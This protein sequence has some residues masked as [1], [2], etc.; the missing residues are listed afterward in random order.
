MVGFLVGWLD[1]AFRVGLF[2]LTAGLLTSL[3]AMGLRWRTPRLDVRLSGDALVVDDKASANVAASSTRSLRIRATNTGR[4]PLNVLR[5]GLT[6]RGAP[7]PDFR[8]EGNESNVQV[9]SYKQTDAYSY[10]T[11]YIHRLRPG[12]FVELVADMPSPVTDVVADLDYKGRERPL[13]IGPT[14]AVEPGR[15]L[16]PD[17]DRKTDWLKRLEL[18]GSIASL[19]GLGLTIYTLF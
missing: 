19:I 8:N 3:G 4:L 6:Y 10:I 11:V 16:V 7:A 5:F 9:K 2:V 13:E 17:L 18:Y 12:R 14:V 15:R 1:D